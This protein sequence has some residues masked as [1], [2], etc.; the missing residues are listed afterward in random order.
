MAIETA[1]SG[2][3]G[4]PMYF[5][6]PLRYPGGKR[7]LANF[8]RLLFY[9]NDLLDGEYAEPYAGGAS[10]ALSLL[11]GEFVTQVHINDIDPAVAA[12]WNVVLESTEELVKRIRDVTVTIAEWERQRSVQESEDPDLIDLAFSTFFLNRTN[13]SGI[14]KGGVIG[15]KA[16]TGRWALDA[17]F[18][19]SDLI[20]RIE[21]V[22]R[23][24]SRIKT[25]QLDGAEFISCVLPSLPPKALAYLDPPYYVKGG[26]LYEHHYRHEDHERIAAL[27]G[28]I[29]QPWVVS[30]DYVPEIE[31]MYEGYRQRLYGIH[32]SAQ[33]RY[34]G[35]EVMVFSPQLRIP[36][37]V[38]PSKVKPRDVSSA[39]SSLPRSSQVSTGSETTVARRGSIARTNP[40][41]EVG[42]CC[43]RG[44][45]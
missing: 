5:L 44:P 43:S 42:R 28:T 7:K 18:N 37:V 22:A 11:Y 9:Q 20:G 4:A 23:Y 10:V 15:G 6:S 35:T 24:R 36:E 16:Q 32:Y 45:G 39:A 25:Y 2:D 14:I 29:K 3:Q 33:A 27:V 21:K 31:K 34:R 41:L 1:R 12:F 40:V 19:K 13:R 17:R 38:D 26:D 8:I 30:Y